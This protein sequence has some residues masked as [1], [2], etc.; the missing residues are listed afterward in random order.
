MLTNENIIELLGDLPVRSY[1]HAVCK[2]AMK[3]SKAQSDALGSAKRHSIRFVKTA[4]EAISAKMETQQIVITDTQSSDIVA[5][6]KKDIFTAIEKDVYK[7]VVRD[8]LTYVLVAHNGISPALQQ[9]DSY[10]G[11]SGAVTIYN[12]INNAALYTLNLWYSDTQRNLDVYYPD[13]IEKYYYDTHDGLWKR[14]KDYVNE[15]WPIVWKDNNNQ[16]LGIALVEFDIGE[17]DITEAVQ[18]Q[19][20]MN[21]AL[22]DMLAT[23]R[24]MGWPQRVLKNASKETYLLNQWQQPALYDVAGYPIPRKIE[25]TPGAILMLQGEDSD[26]V[27]LPAAEVNT[28]A[29]DK[30]EKYMTEVTT[31]P[32]HYF[33]GE[34]PSG[35]ALMNSELRLNHKVESHQLYLSP[36][37]SQMFTLMLRLSNTFGNTAY[38]IDG[39]TDVLWYPPEIEDEGLRMDKEKARVTNATVMFNSGFLSVEDA[40]RYSFPDKD[41]AEITAMANR[42]KAEKSITSL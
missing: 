8:G 34:W 20:D 30:L 2:E 23:S 5:Q 27:Q 24:T 19:H 11:K 14:R 39:I 7:A 29:L 18:L 9:V 26:L 17:S 37:V 21:E 40:L 33:N 42:V 22:L 3:L 36:S 38:V 31:V 13:R 28:A 10:D 6:W 25:L 1:K 15:P 16:P 4:I 35:V 41:D 12:S 32:S